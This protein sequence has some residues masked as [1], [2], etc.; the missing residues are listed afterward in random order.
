[1]AAEHCPASGILQLVAVRGDTGVAL[2]LFPRDSSTVDTVTTF[3]VHPPGMDPLPLPGAALALRWFGSAA[4]EAFEALS[5]EVRLTRVGRGSVSGRVTARL[6]GVE[7]SD[8]LVVSGAFREV[9][10]A[11]AD[12]GCEATMQR[13]RVPA[14]AAA[15]AG[16]RGE[17][18][19]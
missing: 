7:R 13:H 19:A 6:R 1:M 15:S 3:I 12:P 4:L 17:P 2:A 16:A 11:R 14:G 10:F 9:P 18:Q 8:T 5:G